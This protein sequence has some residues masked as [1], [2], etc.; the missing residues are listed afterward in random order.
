[1]KI[2]IYLIIIICTLFFSACLKTAVP[3]NTISS[4]VVWNDSALLDAYTVNVYANM[5][6][7]QNSGCDL[8]N[9]YSL[10]ANNFFSNLSDESHTDFSWLWLWY[11][12]KP[13]KMSAQD[14]WYASGTPFDMWGYYNTIRQQ[15]EFLADITSSK[16]PA[17]TIQVRT[18]R[19]RW[20]RAFTYFIL[21]R[22]IG[23]VPLITKPQSESL[24]LDS[25]YTPRSSEISVYDF[26]ISELNDIINNSELP[27]VKYDNGN[28]TLYEALALESQI[29][30]YAG[31]LANA[32]STDL[33]GL[34]GVPASRAADLYQTAYTAS[35][36]IINSGVFSLFNQLPNNKSENFRQL[37][38]TKQNSEVIFSKEFNGPVNGVGGFYDDY[39][40]PI[41]LVGGW[42]GNASQP[43]FEM[44]EEFEWTNG[45]PG[46]PGTFDLNALQQGEWSH[47]NLWKNKDPRFFAT[48]YTQGTTFQG[49]S[50][51]M[52]ANMLDANGNLINQA[53]ANY[54]PGLNTG[55][56]V[57][58]Y[59]N[60]ALIK[61]VGGS[62][63]T[64]VIVHR[65]GGILLNYAEA[66]F[67]LNKTS[68]ALTAI[69]MIRVRAGVQPLTTLTLDN[70]HHERKVELAFENGDRYYSLKSWRQ[71][72]TVLSHQY[73]GLQ[74]TLDSKTGNFKVT[75]LNNIDGSNPPAFFQKDYYLPIP[76]SIISANPSIVQNP[77]Y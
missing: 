35:Q 46:V 58:K 54:N 29:A 67:A 50:L 60:D 36:K 45:T 6:F 30:L 5:Y 11:Y 33:N 77:N 31:N 71:A 42:P 47:D 75:V 62:S 70:I 55:F 18:A 38:L 10:Y 32:G 37:F 14:F 21:A 48:L 66:A 52:N 44:A 7:L 61:P 16:L 20:A 73:S 41:G 74:Y 59:C 53:G 24:P 68:D 57:L 8:T 43:Y 27:A 13:G 12:F 3:L 76:T 2:R 28:P 65:L 22:N 4:G 26:C 69:N 39:E 23:A 25:L 72:T 49:V 17:K 56:G 9:G 15:N 19:M 64:D 1:M 40:F 51:Q 34:L 63:N